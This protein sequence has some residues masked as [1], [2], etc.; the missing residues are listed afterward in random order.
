MPVR[1]STTET[2]EITHAR[3]SKI[4]INVDSKSI[5]FVYHKGYKDQNGNWHYVSTHEYTTTPEEMVQIASKLPD[6]N[7]NMYDNIAKFAYEF[8][9][10]KGLISGTIE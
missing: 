10:Q 8:L 4:I 2:L 6:P 7:M 5:T 3:I 1:L 9:I